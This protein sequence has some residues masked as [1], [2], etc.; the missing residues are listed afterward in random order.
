[1]ASNRVVTWTTSNSNVATVSSAGLVTAVAVGSVTITATSEGQSGTATISVV[2]ASVAIVEVSPSSPTVSV[3]QA[4]TLTVT[5]KDKDGVVLTGR[6]VAFT[7]SNAAVATVSP[8]GVVI[9][10]AP[11]SATIVA[12]S[13][14]KSASVTNDGDGR[15]PRR[16]FDCPTVQPSTA[17]IGVGQTTTLSAVTRD[18]DG[19]VLTG[20]TIT[21]MSSNGSA[22]PVSGNGAVTGV[23]VGT[24][25]ITAMSEGK[26]GT[27]TISVTPAGC[28]H[29]RDSAAHRL[30]DRRPKRPRLPQS[31]KTG[32]E[33]CSPAAASFGRPATEQLPQ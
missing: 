6:Q 25:T 3:N 30:G 10:V 20:R 32:A 2:P 5:L 1:V 31:R 18:A 12:T 33:T 27:A 24:A 8:I 7:S 15:S 29:Y 22:A 19:N 4:V 26:S 11:G 17:S 21:W 23:A 16:R 14:G 13:E 28:R 9:G